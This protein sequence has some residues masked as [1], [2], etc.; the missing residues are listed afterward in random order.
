MNILFLST[1]NP[2]PPDHGHYIRTYNILKYIVSYHNV[3][4]LAFIK[5]K[6]NFNNVE[7]IRRMCKFADVFIN[8]DDESR[9]RFFLSLLINIFSPLPYIAQKYYQKNMRQ[10]IKEILKENKI[11]IVHFD[12]L[13][14]ARYLTEVEGIPKILTEHNVETFR[15]LSLLKNSRNIIFKM[16]MYLQYIKLKRYEKNV[17]PNFDIC[18]TVS[19]HDLN[20]LKTMSPST[21]C[22]VIPNGVDTT[23]FMPDGRNPLPNSLIWVGGMDNL[24]NREAVDFFLS[25]IFP[26]IQ[27]EMPGVKFTAVGK[28]P[29]K[30]LLHLARTNK[31][32]EVIGYVNDVRPFINSAAVY[33]APIKS[34]SGTKLKVLNA[35]SMAKP[36]VTTSMG[37]EGI[38]A[39]DYEH[40]MIAD[41]P[42]LFATKTINLLNNPQY[43]LKIGGNGRKLIIEKYDWEI[44]G[45]R[46][47][48]LYEGVLNVKYSYKNSKNYH[49]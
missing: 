47:N 4:F 13:H 10:K 35:L 12:M 46:M 34:G 18:A 22:V 1:E 24:Y 44:I 37:V 28:L 29:T 17:C 3:Y 20:L 30:K 8:P 2:Y 14:L 19:E 16:F 36:V 41:D 40:L 7:P 15:I 39:K 21:K 33:V 9:F 31:N 6:E 26:F 25:K 49:N 5:N 23:Y 45:K 11:D 43:A 38:D 42:E 32:I 27:R 48:R